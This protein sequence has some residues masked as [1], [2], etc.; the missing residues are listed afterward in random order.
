MRQLQRGR[1]REREGERERGSEGERGRE[2]EGEGEEGPCSPRRRKG[3][4]LER[5]Q[6]IS[7]S[8]SRCTIRLAF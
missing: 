5:G 2:A 8:L 6:G 1:E 7:E 4:R 3:A